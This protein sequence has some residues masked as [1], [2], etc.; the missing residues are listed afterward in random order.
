MNDWKIVIRVTQSLK[1]FIQIRTLHWVR[2]TV[3]AEQSERRKRH[4]VDT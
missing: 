3:R 4:S 2:L 1:G